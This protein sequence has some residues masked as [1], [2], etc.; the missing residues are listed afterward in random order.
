MNPRALEPISRTL[1]ALLNIS[2]FLSPALSV[3]NGLF[4]QQNQ[5]PAV[6]FVVGI[7][8]AILSYFLTTWWAEWVSRASAIALGGPTDQTARVRQL[9]DTQ[10]R[11]MTASQ[12]L[13]VITGVLGVIGLMIAGLSSGLGF[14][15]V[16]LAIILGL[17][18]WAAYVSIGWYK[19]WVA[20]A[21]TWVETRRITYAFESL[22]KT[23][24]NWYMAGLVLSGI[25][26]LVLVFTILP[27]LPLLGMTGL[28][29][30]LISLVSIGLGVV[31]LWYW[32]E[33]FGTFTAHATATPAPITATNP[34]GL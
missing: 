28:I 16:V 12:V 1:V 34:A 13:L 18:F 29:S 11:W 7:L 2:R 22:A 17:I 9:S 14:L 10:G 23:L 33:F 30:L 19:S 6:A 21:T 25:S 26:A 15:L 4:P 5:N 32:R 20:D 8:T 31:I 27:A 24:Q 3:L